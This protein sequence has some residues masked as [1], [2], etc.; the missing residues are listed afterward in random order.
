M[1]AGP[2]A[3]GVLLRV[4]VT[5]RSSRS[6]IAGWLGDELHVRLHAP[7]ADGR[8]NAELTRVLADVLGIGSRAIAIVAGAHAR[9]KQV[10]IRGLDESA[11]R[12]RLARVMDVIG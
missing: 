10:R 9:H 3:D 2:A 11:L 4:R 7:P 1:T 6:G 8:A 5:P 12:E